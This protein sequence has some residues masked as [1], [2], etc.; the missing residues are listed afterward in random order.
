M[1]SLNIL[2]AGRSAIPIVLMHA[3]PLTSEMYSD[4]AHALLIQQSSHPVVLVDLPGFGSAPMQD[5][6]TIAGAMQDLHSALAAKSLRECV[7][8]GTS[9][10]GYA[11]FAYYRL[12]SEEVE[13]L[14]FSNT[15]A[16]A[17]DDKA[18]AGREEYAL[19]V[20]KRGAQA[21]ID[22]Q[23]G[24]LLSKNAPTEKPAVVAK[25]T[26]IIESIPPAAI[27]AALRAMAVRDDS[28]DLLAQITCPTLVISSDADTLIPPAATKDIALKIE[29]ARY[30]EIAGAGHLSPLEAPGEW[31]TLV[32]R[33][34][35]QL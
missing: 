22:R 15:K 14:I 17:D 27:A 9:M 12:Y 29:G 4:A 26:A 25:L 5:G 19:D 7:I 16:G 8:G 33:F 3:F 30:E 6:W 13:G 11:A 32:S 20:E 1:V 18:R 28:T 2:G 24:A 31:A 35:T 21:A 10:G 34:V 23:L